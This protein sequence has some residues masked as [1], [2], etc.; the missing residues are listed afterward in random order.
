MSIEADLIEELARLEGYNILPTES[1]RPLPK[2]KEV[3]NS[4]RVS[5]FLVS[6][7]YSEVITY[8]FIDEQD[9]N[10]G[11]VKK[12]HLVVSNPISQNMNVMRSSLWPGLV[13]T[14]AS[15]LNNGEENQKLFEIGS[16]FKKDK[17]GSVKEILQVG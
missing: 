8:S 17:A 7:G 11:G 16:I 15:N 2:K 14:Y 3:T 13:N 9:A 6:Q 10:L 5:A 12:D 1:L 4:H